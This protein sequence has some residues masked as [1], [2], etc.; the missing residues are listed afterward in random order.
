MAADFNAAVGDTIELVIKATE[1][2]QV[3]GLST[4]IKIE[5]VPTSSYEILD[6]TVGS[7][8]DHWKENNQDI[9]FSRIQHDEA[10]IASA[11]KGGSQ[12]ILVNKNEVLFTLSLRA[13]ETWQN[14]AR[15]AVTNFSAVNKQG[16]IQSAGGYATIQTSESNPDFEPTNPKT[17]KLNGN[18]P[19]PFNPS[20]Q[21]SFN[22]DQNTFVSLKVFNMLGQEVATLV[23]QPMQKG[24]HNIE[25]N[26]SKLSSGM[27]IYRLVADNH[28]Q[29]KK[30]ML[31]K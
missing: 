15:V 20:T 16:Q 8:F 30:M 29:T 28:V 25:F 3:K 13:T 1:Y 22:V 6:V 10:V 17:T 4:R 14:Q 27:Y 21:I 26:A 5:N 18:Y 12:D 11:G 24:T 9:E 2:F 31:V 23:N 19:N 7:W